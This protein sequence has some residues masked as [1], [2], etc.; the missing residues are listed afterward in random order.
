[1]TQDLKTNNYT[2]LIQANLAFINATLEL[3]H[4]YD[5]DE[6][7]KH[8]YYHIEKFPRGVNTI[9]D[10]LEQCPLP[11]EQDLIDYLAQKLETD[12]KKTIKADKLSHPILSN[13]KQALQK[14]DQDYI[15][16]FLTQRPKTKIQLKININKT[17]NNFIT[18]L[19]VD[20]TKKLSIDNLKL[21]DV[22]IHQFK[23]SINKYI[24]DQKLQKENHIKIDNILKQIL[25]LPDQSNLHY[26][27]FHQS[28]MGK[29][30][31]TDN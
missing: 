20:I 2:K 26:T 27:K 3:V 11:Q 19:G 23:R 16:Y 30:N 25:D 21:E 8:C 6:L 12:D 17:Q 29:I 10:F 31:G 24:L 4:K 7:E 18:N 13:L 15:D 1:M 14:S 22:E 9:Y 5:C 28:L